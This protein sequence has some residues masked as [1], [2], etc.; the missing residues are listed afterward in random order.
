MLAAIA[1]LTLSV[2]TASAN[3]LQV[4]NLSLSAG[5]ASHVFVEFDV[6]WSNSWRAEWEES[7]S[8]TNWDAAWVF[9]KFR[10]QGDDGYSHASLATSDSD[11][12]VPAGATLDVG[13]TGTN[14]VGV[15]IYR[16]AT[17][18]GAI[19]FDNVQLRWL[20]AQDG[21]A[22]T[23]AV[24][25]TVHAI[26]MVYVP[27]GSFDAGDDTAST[28]QGQFE[29]GALGSPLQIT[30]E[31]SLTLGG[32]GAGS[33]GN[34]NATAM[35]QGDDFN[36]S[37]SQTLPAAFPKG[38]AA[39]Y[40][41]KYEITQGQY[42][43][44]LNQLSTAQATVRYPAGYYGGNRFSI[45]N[46]G[47]YIAEAPDRACNI[48]S[49]GDG[50]AY[51]D[52]AGI[53]PMSELEFEKACR[54]PLTGVPDEYAWGDVFI[55]AQTGHSGV[56]GSGTET[57]TPAGANC[58]YNTA[59][60]G[61]GPA[62]V[63]IFATTNSTRSDSG[64]SYWGIMEMSGNVWERPVSVGRPDGRSFTGSHGD[65]VLSAGADFTNSD[66]PSAASALGSGSRGGNWQRENFRTRLSGRRHANQPRPARSTSFAGWRGVRSAP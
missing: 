11:H 9:V 5:D 35:D 63:G 12:V 23:A 27:E 7:G 3:D 21:V 26:E 15:F 45:T 59:L 58:V 28:I 65:G 39:F 64:A 53:R 33:L 6:S 16:A 66:W 8:W 48:I 46:T 1:A 13:M 52:W 29:E 50:A 34:H 41:M 36:D 38:Y 54:G 61:S 42:A 49:W 31:G 14:G 30:S 57:A 43:D 22:D 25:V 47:T 56:D 18:S 17:N 20:Y 2:V 55:T 60:G 24:D 62:R 32:S 51:A 19:D 44:F 4:T 10:N 40:S 37:T